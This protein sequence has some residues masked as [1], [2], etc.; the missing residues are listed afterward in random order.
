M[1]HATMPPPCGLVAFPIW[2]I[3]FTTLVELAPP[4]P[5]AGTP[6]AFEAKVWEAIAKLKATTQQHASASNPPPAEPVPDPRVIILTDQVATLR[7]EIAYLHQFLSDQEAYSSE[8]DGEGE[9]ETT[10]VP[11]NED[12]GCCPGLEE[13]P[14]VNCVLALDNLAAVKNNVADRQDVLE[15]EVQTLACL[16]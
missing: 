4:A 16:T 11:N 9:A 2:Y 7:G 5:P 8:Y 14:C 12:H 1:E 10:E 3:N 13:Q 15:Q 6:S